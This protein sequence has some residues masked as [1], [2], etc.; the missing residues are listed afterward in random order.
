MYV[1]V[2]QFETVCAYVGLVCAYVRRCASMCD[3][4]RSVRLCTSMCA[5]VRLCAPM[6]VDGRLCESVRLCTW[7]CTYV[8]RY[9]LI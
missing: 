5:C 7:M 3:C 9:A 2:R 4:A 8:R 6:F 1:D